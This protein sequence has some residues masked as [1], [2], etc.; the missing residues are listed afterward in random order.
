MLRLR[1]CEVPDLK[2]ICEA[3]LDFGRVPMLWDPWVRLIA[4]VHSG[5][6]SA[7]SVMTRFD[8]PRAV[9]RESSVPPEGSFLPICI[10]SDALHAPDDQRAAAHAAPLGSF[11]MTPYAPPS[12]VCY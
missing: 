4:S 7:V 11:G 9:I 8:S 2:P 12:V 5:H 10:S 3:N 6:T 1:G